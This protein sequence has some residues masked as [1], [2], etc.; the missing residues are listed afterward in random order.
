MTWMDLSRSL[1]AA[2]WKH[3]REP[4]DSGRDENGAPYSDGG[5]LHTWSRGAERITVYAYWEDD[6]TTPLCAPLSYWPC[7]GDGDDQAVSIDQGLAVKVGPWALRQ[8]L[9]LAVDSVWAAS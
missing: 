9:R 4:F 5:I 2:G 6:G 3:S 7:G 8:M 1:R